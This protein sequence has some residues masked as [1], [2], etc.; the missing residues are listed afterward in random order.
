MSISQ[1]SCYRVPVFFIANVAR[2]VLHITKLAVSVERS[3]ADLQTTLHTNVLWEDKYLAVGLDDV[4]RGPPEVVHDRNN[5]Q[6]AIEV[7]QD[8]VCWRCQQPKE[9]G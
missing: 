6:V 4:G 1:G 9:K 2:A 3:G 8:L 7:G 5:N